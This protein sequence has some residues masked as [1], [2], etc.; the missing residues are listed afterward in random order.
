MSRENV[1]VVRRIHEAWNRDDTEAILEHLRAEFEYV[2]PAYA[3]EPGVKCGHEGFAKVMENLRE[4]FA[5]Y[6][7][8]PEE[9]IDQGDHVIVRSRFKAQGR[10]SGAEIERWRV[11]AWTLRGGK[12]LR[13]QWFDTV[14]EALQAVGLSE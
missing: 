1:E 8:D 3:V 11:H 10:G 2:N 4:S 14:E 5:P 7:H 13:V 9:F 12:A 6:R